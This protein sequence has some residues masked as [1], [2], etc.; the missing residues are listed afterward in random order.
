MSVVVFLF[1]IAAALLVVALVGPH[2]LYWRSRPRAAGQPSDA[3]LALGRVAAFGAAGAFVF[4]GCSVLGD[5]D[6]GAWSADEVRK[7]AEDVAFTLGDESRMP[8]DAVD[9]YASLIEAGVVE[10]GAGQGPSY[11]VSVERVGGGHDYE[12][13]AGGAGS[14][15]CMR[16]T[17]SKSAGGGV[18]VPGA[19]G[20]SGDSIARYDLSATVDDGPC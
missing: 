12:V 6:K 11:A 18:F 8:G 1:L 20:G 14:A 5:I 2:R 15:V 3:A 9:G 16:V 7:T 13:S 17:E 19:D 4:G 10:A